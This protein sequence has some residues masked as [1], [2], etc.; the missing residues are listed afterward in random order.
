MNKYPARRISKYHEYT[1]IFFIVCALAVAPKLMFVSAVFLGSVFAAVIIPVFCENHQLL[2]RRESIVKVAIISFVCVLPFLI[3]PIITS[4]LYAPYLTNNKAMYTV[5]FGAV[6]LKNFIVTFL[7]LPKKT[8]E[9]VKQRVPYW[10]LILVVLSGSWTS[11][12]QSMFDKHRNVTKGIESTLA[13]QNLMLEF[14]LKKNR[15]PTSNVEINL[16]NILENMPQ[17]VKSI[18]VQ[19]EG[20][21]VINYDKNMLGGTDDAIELYLKITIKDDQVSWKCFEE[22]GFYYYDIPPNCSPDIGDYR[23]QKALKKV[24]ESFDWV[25]STIQNSILE[26]DHL[27][28]SDNDID[29]L[30]T[31]ENKLQGIKSIIIQRDDIIVITYDKNIFNVINRNMDD[32]NDPKLYLKI[33]TEDK[34]VSLRCIEVE[35]VDSSR[36]PEACE[37]DIENNRRRKY[38]KKGIDLASDIKNSIVEFHTIKGR[39]PINNEDIGVLNAFDERPRI[40]ESITVQPEGI[41][42]IA[43]DSFWVKRFNTNTDHSELY[44][45]INIEGEKPFLECVEEKGIGLEYLPED[46]VSDIESK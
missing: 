25:I 12:S 40:V 33:K 24:E 1:A 13:I 14:Y 20:V 15:F 18:T 19:P 3:I 35:G 44:L 21:I 31:S 38:I 30:N 16:S 8:C 26:A 37:T 11:P 6:G 2:R 39:F 41:I 34:K 7:C 45:R 43:Y 27:P 4:V 46:C 29:L 22:K 10:L 42:V 28:K 17:M 5:F 36:L 23:R 9:T 32:S